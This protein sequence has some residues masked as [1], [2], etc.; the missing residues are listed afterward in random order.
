MTGLLAVYVRNHLAAARGGLD[1]FRRVARSTEGTDAGPEVAALAAEVDVDLRT[2]LAIAQVLGIG[3]NKP[4]GFAARAGETL[5]RLKPN[6][7][8]VR[9]SPLTDLIEIE[10]LLDAVAAKLAGGTACSVRPTRGS[11]GYA[12]GSRIC[13][14]VRSINARESTRFTTTRPL[15]CS[16]LASVFGAGGTCDP[17][18]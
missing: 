3:E 7:S 17:S 13:T 16:A 5:G 6:G 9:R 8:L 15:A 11:A 2:L 1:L 10:G 14:G 18:A 12:T 4:F